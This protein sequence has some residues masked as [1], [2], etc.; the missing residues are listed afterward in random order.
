MNPEDMQDFNLNFSRFVCDFKDRWAKSNRHEQRFLGKNQNWLDSSIPFVTT[1]T[2]RGRKAIDF[3]DCSETTKV[4][5]CKNLRQNVSLPV[6]SYATQISLRASGQTEAAKIVKEITASP[7]RAAKFRKNVICVKEKQMTPEEALVVLVEAKLSRKQYNVIRNAAPDKFPAY[8][9][10]QRAKKKCYPKVETMQISESSAKVSLQG[11]LDHT[12]ERL[13]L[14]QKNVIDTLDNEEISNLTLITKWGFD[15]SSG[16]SSYKQ[17]FHGPGASDSSVLITSIVPL[18]LVCNDKIVWQNPRPSS[19]RFCRPLKIEFTKETASILVREKERVDEELNDLEMSVVPVGERLVKVSHKLTLVMI[20]GKVC[21]A[22]TET[23]SSQRCY[24]CNSTSKE[25][26]S[27][28]EMIAKPVKTE[29]LEFGLSIL[30]GW[31]RFFECIIHL[32]YKL[33]IK[34]WKAASDDDKKIIDST[35]ARIQNEFRVK[36]GLI[37]DQPKPGFGNSN[38]G[39]TARRFFENAEVSADITKIDL[40][41]IKK[42]HVILITVSSGHEIHSE[43]FKH[44]CHNTARHF[45]KMYPWYKMPTTLHKYL[46]HGPEIVSHALLPIGQLSEEAQEARN[47]DFKSYREHFSRKCNRVKS[48]EDILNRLLLSSDPIISSK[49]KLPKKN[50][51]ALPKSVVELLIPPT[52]SVSAV[53]SDDSDDETGDAHVD[54]LEDCSSDYSDSTQ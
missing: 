51:Q 41:L 39:N 9:L 37:I 45:V 23:T 50:F 21:N 35:K 32:S 25:F 12:I 26:N 10:L 31:I 11:L 19:T 49:I 44:F 54:E 24:I 29:T 20:D 16:H 8:T 7:S 28:D 17:A 5:K 34:K 14:L 6:L 52:I 40:E 4:K 22:I 46:I 2:K 27:I 53:R 33:P 13:V 3:D 36:T 48:N 42:M 43:K 38:D 1:T 30:H 47:K 18:R 15:G